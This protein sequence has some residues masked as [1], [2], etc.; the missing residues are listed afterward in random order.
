METEEIKDP[1][2]EVLNIEPLEQVK[3]NELVKVENIDTSIEHDFE[4]A[5]TNIHDM[6]ETASTAITDL[7]IIAKQSQHPRAF[8]VYGTLLK[9]VVEA[10]KE[11]LS[12]QK[13]MREMDAKKSSSGTTIENAL[14]VGS[15]SELNKLIKSNRE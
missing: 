12:V 1:I 5:R 13:Q 4:S 3:V 8:E 14:F 7:S 15:T 10:N 11:L 6:I 2:G 9:N